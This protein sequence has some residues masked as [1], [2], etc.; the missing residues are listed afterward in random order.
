MQLFFRTASLTHSGVFND[1][2]FG[3]PNFSKLRVR[4]RLHFG[5]PELLEIRRQFPLRRRPR[6]RRGVD[7]EPRIP[8]HERV[9]GRVR[10][11]CVVGHEL[12]FA[13][14]VAK[15]RTVEG[16]GEGFSRVVVIVGGGFRE[17]YVE[18]RSSG[19]EGGYRV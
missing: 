2:I 18:R 10:R 4:R 6:P 16:D 14:P 15:I 8:P 9:D 5:I 19:G 12:H 1:F 13:D 11:V 17:R 3:Y 7:E